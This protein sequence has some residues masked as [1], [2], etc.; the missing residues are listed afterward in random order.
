M[1]ILLVGVY[2]QQFPASTMLIIHIATRVLE[3]SYFVAV[4]CLPGTALERSNSL[5]MHFSVFGSYLP[6]GKVADL[7]IFC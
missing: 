4:Q 3:A 5:N 1:H 2:L 6:V 7:N